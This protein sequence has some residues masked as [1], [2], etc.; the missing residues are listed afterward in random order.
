M[1]DIAGELSRI[2]EEDHGIHPDRRPFR[3]HITVARVR[4]NGRI[5]INRARTTLE[6]SVSKFESENYSIPV[7]RFKLISSEL[8]PQGPIYTEQRSYDF[9]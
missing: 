3:S 4:R 9:S 5:N 8:T 1:A 6:D 2:L 7:E